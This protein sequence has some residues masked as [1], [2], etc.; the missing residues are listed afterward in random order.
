MLLKT[1]PIMLIVHTENG[2]KKKK[3][4][5]VKICVFQVKSVLPYL[6]FVSQLCTKIS[7]TAENQPYLS[8]W[9]AAFIY[10]N[11]WRSVS[12]VHG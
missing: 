3:I 11:S 7:E 6:G 4:F 9:C 10:V 12:E 8:F 2:Q 1:E 5:E